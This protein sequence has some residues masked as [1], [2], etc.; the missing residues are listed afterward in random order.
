MDLKRL[1]GSLS[2]IILYMLYLV[3]LSSCGSTMYLKEYEGPR[4]PK[5]EVAV[6]ELIGSGLCSVNDK[7]WK[8]MEQLVKYTPGMPWSALYVEV[9]PGRRNISLQ[10]NGG[11]WV[12]KDLDVCTGPYSFD[13]RAGH[14]Y[15]IECQIE[16]VSDDGKKRTGKLYWTIKDGDGK[17]IKFH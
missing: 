2:R 12:G 13:F 10:C 11:G 1:K 7:S 8:N 5:S 3:F 17:E 14:N 6:I 9:T 16:L 4:L 15:K